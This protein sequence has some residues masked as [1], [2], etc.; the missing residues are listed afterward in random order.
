MALPM[1]F[2]TGELVRLDV[3]KKSLFHKLVCV[4][5][6]T[7]KSIHTKVK[8]KEQLAL[9]EYELLLFSLYT[10]SPPRPEQHSIKSV[11]FE[12]VE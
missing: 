2:T 9:G 10:N 5:I 12:F 1:L 11:L 7:S 3:V 8:R 4:I 6:Y